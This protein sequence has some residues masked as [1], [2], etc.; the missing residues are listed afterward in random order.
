MKWD[1]SDFDE[2]LVYMDWLEE[3]GEL[4]R[5][6]KYIKEFR[7]YPFKGNTWLSFI[8]EPGQN[9]GYILPVGVLSMYKTTLEAYEVL[10]KLLKAYKDEFIRGQLSRYNRPTA[11]AN[12][13]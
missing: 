12:H 2:V 13:F 1:L 5:E 4:T 8:G 9:V 10:I 11:K 6:W 7:L 3:R